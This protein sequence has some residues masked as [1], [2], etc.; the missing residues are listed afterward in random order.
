MGRGGG[1]GG[2]S[3]GGGGGFRSSGGR[4][5]SFGRGSSSFGS[6]RG[7]SRSGGFTPRRSSGGFGGGFRPHVP[8]PPP[9]RPY[10]GYGH[11]PYSH[12]PRRRTTG[13]GCL[14]AFA[15]LMIVFVIILIFATMSGAFGAVNSVNSI[16][17]STVEREKLDSSAAIVGE[18]Y[19]D[20]LGWIRS[21][22]KLTSGMKAFYKE[23]GVAPYLY[24]TDTVNGTNYPSSSDMDTY[25]NTLYDQLFED[26]AH[27]LLLFHEYEPSEYSMWYVCGA[28]AKTVMDQEACDI[29]LDY[30]DNYYY[31]DLS[32]EEMFSTAFEKAG[33]RIMK[34]TK[35][36]LPMIII[37]IAAVVIVIILFRW[38]KK[39]KAQKNLEAEQTERI[40]NADLKTVGS[41]KDDLSDLEEKYK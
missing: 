9:R 28:Q 3:S 34:V 6:S 33:E 16:T 27:I 11:R 12:Y 36:P 15:T 32:D 26:E 35:S 20:E 10:Y 30:M 19:T 2:R 7:G 23:T 5:S 40:L 17:K 39:A 41:Q 1:G 29:L 31:S 37:A 18:Y 25:A 24:I 8:P 22:T 21:S 38:W 13:G 14:S 4:M